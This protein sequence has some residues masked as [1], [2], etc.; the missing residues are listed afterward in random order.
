VTAG[1]RPAPG[2]LDIAAGVSLVLAS[3][4]IVGLPPV[5]ADLRV[6]GAMAAV[7]VALGIL[8]ALGLVACWVAASLRSR[9]VGPGVALF[10]VGIALWGVMLLV[11]EP[12]L[13]WRLGLATVGLVSQALVVAGWFVLRSFSPVAFVALMAL[14]PPALVAMFAPSAH[15]L[16]AALVVGPL[17]AFAIAVPIARSQARASR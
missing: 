10:V 6:S 9:R 2:L 12:A 5:S 16:I 4:A 3:V 13:G 7:V 14:A 11:A 17:L 8:G 1:A 15:V